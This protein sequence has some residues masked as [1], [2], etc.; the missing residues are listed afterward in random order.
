[1]EKI[2]KN[3]VVKL[4]ADLKEKYSNEEL[5]VMLERSAVTIW[6]WGNSANKRIPCLS[7]LN[8]LRKLLIDKKGESN[9]I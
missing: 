3:D 6:S 8:V 1:M 4:M 7:D 2:L 5:G 9:A